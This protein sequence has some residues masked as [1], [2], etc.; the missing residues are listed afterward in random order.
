MGQWTQIEIQ[1]IPI[2]HKKNHPN[3]L[4][5]TQKWLRKCEK[6]EIKPHSDLSS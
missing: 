2:K 6:T 3:L 1:E 5:V 4:Q